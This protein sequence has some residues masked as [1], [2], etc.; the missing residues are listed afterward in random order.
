MDLTLFFRV[1]WRYRLL[2]VSGLLLA[3]L[4][5]FFAMV[6]ISPGGDPALSL[7]GEKEYASYTT[8]FVTQKGFPWGRLAEGDGQAAA[9]NSSRLASLASLYSQLAVSD[10]VDEM[11]KAALGNSDWTIESAPVLDANGTNAALPLVRIAAL[12]PTP[13]GAQT[14]AATA[15]ASL[16]SFVTTRQ[17]TNDIPES[18]RV[19]LQLIKGPETAIL[20]HGRSFTQP[21]IVFVLLAM[22]T[23]ALPFI[24]D[25]VR[26]SIAAAKAADAMEER[27]GADGHASVSFEASDIEERRRLARL[28]Q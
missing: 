26:R 1:M 14:T 28:S 13:E 15:A 5:A 8:L 2:V 9:N 23:L 12:A 7:R 10:P 22:I 21:I 17:R 16:Q 24:I 18:D 4:A 27:E 19:V 25:N 20:V 6:K 3:V 11:N